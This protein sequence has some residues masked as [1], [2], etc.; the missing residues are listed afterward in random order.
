M[1]KDQP[2]RWYPQEALGLASGR[3]LSHWMGLGTPA[4]QCGDRP[5]HGAS[6]EPKGRFRITVKISTTVPIA[7]HH[8]G[9]MANLTGRSRT[10]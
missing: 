10:A 6:T 7:H 1:V 5:V 2:C 3:R 9:R 8:T 4:D